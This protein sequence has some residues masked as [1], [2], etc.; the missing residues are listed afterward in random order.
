[1]VFNSIAEIEARLNELTILA[2]RQVARN[3]GVAHVAALRRQEAID[4][5]LSIAKG[6]I[7][8]LPID[9]RHILQDPL[10]YNQELVDAV[11]AIYEVNSN[12]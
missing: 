10:A 7:E 5:V 3:V 8:P 6:E 12:K 1:M 9:K 11:L 4:A 2:I